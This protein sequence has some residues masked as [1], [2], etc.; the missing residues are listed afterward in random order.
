MLVCWKLESVTVSAQ[1]RAPDGILTM[2]DYRPA[3]RAHS[4]HREHNSAAWQLMKQKVANCARTALCVSNTTGSRNSSSRNSSSSSS[5]SSSSNSSQM[6][7]KVSRCAVVAAKGIYCGSCANEAWTAR[8]LS[9]GL[10][11]ISQDCYDRSGAVLAHC[12]L[13]TN[14]LL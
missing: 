2:C 12:L 4:W 11:K 3:A 8:T 10:L 5:N 14:C 9:K 1:C 13:A 7:P 6:H